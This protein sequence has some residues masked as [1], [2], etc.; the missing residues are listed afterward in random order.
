MGE[1]AEQQ[2]A[3]KEQLR[4]NDEIG[5]LFSNNFKDLP[6]PYGGVKA[7]LISDIQTGEI[8]KFYGL[9]DSSQILRVYHGTIDRK[10]PQIAEQGMRA[11]QEAE[12]QESRIYVTA[13]PTL[14]LWHVI[15]NGPHDTLRKAGKID[16]VEVMG[17]SEL[18][19]IQID[20]KWL[21]SHP[22]SQKPLPL[23]GWLKEK[24][25]MKGEDDTRYNA[26]IGTLRSEIEE[27]K[28]GHETSDFGIKFP[29]DYIPPEFIF[30][31][32]RE[33]KRVSLREF[34]KGA[35]ADDRTDA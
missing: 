1:V 27:L 2:V 18:L 17:D 25:N 8:D 26:F 34:Q 15:H 33:G 14:A 32:T 13:S 35:K 6:F 28:S 3:D 24:L 16:S 30:V 10:L 7:K 11:F 4:D 22:D 5:E 29:T 12:H 19:V 21:Q 9:D 23:A 20:K 31:Q